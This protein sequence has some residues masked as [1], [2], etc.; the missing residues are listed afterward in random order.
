MMRRR[1]WELSCPVKDVLLWCGLDWREALAI[2]EASGAPVEERD[3]PHVVAGALHHLCHAPTPFARRL[4]AWLESLHE[5]AVRA[6]DGAPAE[7]VAAWTRRELADFPHPFPALAWAIARDPRPELR[8]VEAQLLWRLQVEGLRALAF[9]KVE[10]IE[11][12]P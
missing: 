10:L 2:A 7:E 9:G 6:V 4:E 1:L 11:V 3:T 5:D 8:R 12:A